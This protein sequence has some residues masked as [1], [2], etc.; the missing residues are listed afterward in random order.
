MRGC[1]A[2]LQKEAQKLTE[3][4]DNLERQLNAINAALKAF[5][6]YSSCRVC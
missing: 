1:I 6:Y 4:K 3:A 2:A 5:E